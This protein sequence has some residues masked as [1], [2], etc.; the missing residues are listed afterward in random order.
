MCGA[1]IV[2]GLGSLTFQA[3]AAMLPFQGALNL[4]DRTLTVN[5]TLFNN[6]ELSD[7]NSTVKLTWKGTDAQPIVAAKVTGADKTLAATVTVGT[8]KSD[9]EKDICKLTS[10]LV[11]EVTGALTLNATYTTSANSPLQSICNRAQATWACLRTPC[12]K[13]IVY[14]CGPRPAGQ[15]RRYAHY[16]RD[17][18]WRQRRSLIGEAQEGVTVALPTGIDVSALSVAGKNAAGGLIGKATKLTLTVG[19]DN[20][21]KDASGKAIA[22]KPAYAV[23]SSSAGTYAGGL[24]G[25]ASFA[26]AFTINSGIFDFGK[27]VA[28]SVSNTSAAPSAGGLF[29]V[30]D[31]SNGDVAVNG[32][33]YTST[34]QNGK[35]DNKHGNYGGLVGKLWGRRTATRCMPLR[36]RMILR[37]RSAWAPTANSPT[38]AA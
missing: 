4:G 6:I 34:L 1:E 24:I 11:G 29:G 17:S 32:G 14:A 20:S 30:L 21:G 12:R 38:R 18:R 10:P 9:T 23:G 25:D 2:G 36:C 16:Q 26:D 27:G 35:D 13:S 7:A 8:P 28:L 31:I 37:C 15:P 5:K 22:I 3:S 33:S 19:K